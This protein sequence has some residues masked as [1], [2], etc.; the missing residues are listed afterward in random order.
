MAGRASSTASEVAASHLVYISQPQAVASTGVASRVGPRANAFAHRDRQYDFLIVSQE[1]SR[2]ANSIWDVAVMAPS[3]TVA[4]ALDYF[5]FE[6]AEVPEVPP[7]H[8]LST[9]MVLIALLAIAA[10]LAARFLDRVVKVPIVVFEIVLGIMLGPSLLG[11]IQPAEFT[12][13]LAD[14][15]LAMRRWRIEI[16]DRYRG[17][18]TGCGW[19][20]RSSRCDLAVF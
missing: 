11:W 8:G 13:M 5:S 10:P 2:T 20:V 9:S 16:P 17:H 4:V 14:F 19:G 3:P 6:A 15:G 18:R 12:D 7:M 1:Q